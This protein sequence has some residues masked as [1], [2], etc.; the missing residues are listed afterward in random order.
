MNR[1]ASCEVLARR[2]SVQDG[3]SYSEGFV[4]NAPADLPDGEYTILFNGHVLHASK[5]RGLW[6]TSHDVTRAA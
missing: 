2:H 1:E 6:L 4:L 3:S 5:D